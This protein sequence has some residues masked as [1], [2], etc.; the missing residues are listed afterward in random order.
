MNQ[1]LLSSNNIELDEYLYSATNKFPST[2]IYSS[3]ISSFFNRKNC[4]VH[5]TEKHVVIVRK[6]IL[7]KNKKATFVKYTDIAGWTIDYKQ[8]IIL[9]KYKDCFKNKQFISIKCLISE[10][11]QCLY[12]RIA[13][14][15]VDL[16]IYPNVEIVKKMRLIERRSQ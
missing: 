13:Q 9:F 15:C 8:S 6:N 12:N 4:D 3:A 14:L 5:L 1:S 11:V 10:F 2:I 16:N 7:F